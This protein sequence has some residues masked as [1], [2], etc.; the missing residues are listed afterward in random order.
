MGD[1]K[2]FLDDDF[3]LYSK[4]AK[5]LYHEYIDCLNA[6][7]DPGSGTYEVKNHSVLFNYTDGRRI[8]IA[9]IGTG[10]DKKDQSPATLSLSYNEDLLTKQ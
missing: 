1:I 3:L 2:F 7:K 9:F 5:I 6:G 10:Y 8:K 4:Q